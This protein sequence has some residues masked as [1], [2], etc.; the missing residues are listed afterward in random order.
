MPSTLRM[1]L[2][3]PSFSGRPSLLQGCLEFMGHRGVSKG[4]RVLLATRK[5][6]IP[7]HFISLSK[8]FSSSTSTLPSL[9]NVSAAHPA[10]WHWARCYA[11]T[12]S[13][14]QRTSCRSRHSRRSAGRRSPSIAKRT[15][16]NSSGLFTGTSTERRA[17]AYGL[18][19]RS[20]FPGHQ[21]QRGGVLRPPGHQP[22]KSA[23]GILRTAPKKDHKGLE[24][25]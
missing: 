19:F 10:S 21:G 4:L 14:R 6:A 7:I 17:P 12:G 22:A 25:R 9:R 2:L 15:G 18:L 5:S 3:S 23:A 8:T 1:V 24:N 13:C 20:L 16:G 11:P